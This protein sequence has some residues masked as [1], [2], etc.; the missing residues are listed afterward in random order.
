MFEKN[1]C[2]AER[3]SELRRMNDALRE[4][5]L[6]WLARVSEETMPEKQAKRRPE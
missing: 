3:E 4:N 5:R 1:A 6:L 2:D